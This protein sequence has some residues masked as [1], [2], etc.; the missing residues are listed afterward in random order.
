MSIFIKNKK[1][2][3][4]FEI[5]ETETAGIILIGSEVKSVKNGAVNFTDAYCIFKDGEM[6]V[7]NLNISQYKNSDEVDPQR[8][9]KLLLTKLQIKKFKKKIEEKGL[10]VVPLNIFVN[11]EGLI[12]MEIALAR[13]KREFDKRNSIADKESDIKLKRVMKKYE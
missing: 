12:K 2:F 13:G 6:Y 4:N 7:K 5:I 9:R 1:A 8:E 10:T 3:F 11:K